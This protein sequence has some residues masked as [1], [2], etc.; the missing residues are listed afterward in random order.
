MPGCVYIKYDGEKV[1]GRQRQRSVVFQQPPRTAAPISRRRCFNCDRPGHF[2]R[3]CRA[4]TRH[5]AYRSFRY[6]TNPNIARFRLNQG[7]ER[8]PMP[9][10]LRRSPRPAGGRPISRQMYF[11]GRCGVDDEQPSVNSKFKHD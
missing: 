11:Q 9:A 4:P 1:L 6:P 5:L 2:A 8:P 3:D 7:L 10:P